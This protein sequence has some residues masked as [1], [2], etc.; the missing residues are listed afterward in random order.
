[1]QSKRFKSKM[2]LNGDTYQTLSESLG[3]TRQTLAEK[4]EGSSEFKQTEID[5]LISRWNLNPHEVVQIFFDSPEVSH[6]S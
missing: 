4:I 3:I 5:K 6:E 1:M 2:V